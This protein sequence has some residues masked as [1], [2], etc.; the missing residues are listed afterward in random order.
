MKSINPLQPAQSVQVD[1]NQKFSLSLNFLHVRELFYLMAQSVV[2]RNGFYE[3][4]LN[5]FP[6][7]F[8]CL[9][10]KSFENTVG[11]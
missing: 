10:Y 5:P 3:S 2:R 8:T 6:K 9:Q 4:I 7:A 11:K 1:M